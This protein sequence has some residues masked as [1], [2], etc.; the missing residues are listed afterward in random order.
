M[1]G[2]SLSLSIRPSDL[3]LCIWSDENNSF[4]GEAD[5]QIYGDILQVRQNR[6]EN[7]A[8][9]LARLYRHGSHYH[10]QP[11]TRIEGWASIRIEM[12]SDVGP[13]IT[14]MDIAVC[15]IDFLLLNKVVGK[16]K[17]SY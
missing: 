4:R 16:L 3:D 13:V 5:G 8:L 10:N 6:R 7:V 1:K 11:V 14:K 17:E 2:E 12:M 15:I 9:R